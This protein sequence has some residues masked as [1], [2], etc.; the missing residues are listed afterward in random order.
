VKIKRLGIAH[1]RLA[2]FVAAA[3]VAACSSTSGPAGSGSVLQSRPSVVEMTTVAIYNSGSSTIYGSGSS[4]CWTASPSPWPSVA[5]SGY[6]KV[7]TLTYD[8][9]CINGPDYIA[10]TYGPP[11]GPDCT[12]TTTYHA[13][14]SYSATNNFLTDC[15]ATPSGNAAFNELFSYDPA[16]SLR[17]RR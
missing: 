6:S 9:T 4:T 7:V 1:C 16:G 3:V 14:F 15:T 10:A 12:F 13:G 2:W 17:K 5:P 11:S 8:T